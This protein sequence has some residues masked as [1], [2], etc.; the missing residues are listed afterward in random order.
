MLDIEPNL[1]CMWLTK[2][3]GKDVFRYASDRN[4][5]QAGDV[6]LNSDADQEIVSMTAGL[7]GQPPNGKIKNET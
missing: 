6:L 1:P 4:L 2:K 7:F 5:C 3:E